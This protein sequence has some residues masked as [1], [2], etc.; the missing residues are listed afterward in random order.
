MESFQPELS[1][2]PSNDPDEGSAVFREAEEQFQPFALRLPLPDSTFHVEPLLRIRSRP[3]AYA[4]AVVRS[5]MRHLENRLPQAL[6]LAETAT[7]LDM[8]PEKVRELAHAPIPLRPIP[9]EVEQYAVSEAL[10][11]ALNPLALQNPEA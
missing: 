8:E 5:A 4:K 7:L 11:Y 6:D 1:L 3:P 2:D 9:G 10:L